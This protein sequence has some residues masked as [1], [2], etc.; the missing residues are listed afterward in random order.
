MTMKC[1]TLLRAVFISFTLAS[2][3][4]MLSALEM[5]QQPILPAR[6]ASQSLVIKDDQQLQARG[7]TPT[8]SASVSPKTGGMLVSIGQWVGISL[9]VITGA[10][11]LF[12]SGVGIYCTYLLY[13]L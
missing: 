5:Q 12:F 2:Q 4:V 1:I 11:L 6:Q 8:A 7:T 10:V 13:G 3:S 9:A